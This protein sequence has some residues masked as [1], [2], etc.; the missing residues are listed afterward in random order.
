M[1]VAAASDVS[2]KVADALANADE[3]LQKQAKI[4]VDDLSA[5]LDEAKTDADSDSSSS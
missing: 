3:V 2:S 5:E 4:N 1:I